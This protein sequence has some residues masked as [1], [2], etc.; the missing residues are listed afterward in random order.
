MT[1]RR[2]HRV[3]G[4]LL[5]AALLALG[6]ASAQ[7]QVFP[8]GGRAGTPPDAQAPRDD[9]GADRAGISLEQATR[10]AR[11]TYGGR[12]VAARPTQRGGE[13]GYQVRLVLDDGRVVNAFVDRQGRVR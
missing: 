13:S 12:V 8:G 1:P 3:L 9:G 2:I 5:L 6:A 11:A 7:G 10:I 4:T